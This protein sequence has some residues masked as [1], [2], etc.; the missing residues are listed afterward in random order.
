MLSNIY[1]V[2]VSINDKDNNFNRN[3]LYLISTSEIKFSVLVKQDEADRAVKA[4]HD[5]F[6]N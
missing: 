6:F 2:N 5:K 4:I 3:R 1:N